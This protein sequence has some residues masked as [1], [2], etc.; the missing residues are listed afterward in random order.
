MKMAWGELRTEIPIQ[1]IT[2]NFHIMKFLVKSDFRITPESST[3]FN[4]T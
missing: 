3:L 1:V 2:K 4:Q